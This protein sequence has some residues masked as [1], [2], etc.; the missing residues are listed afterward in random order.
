MVDDEEIILSYEPTDDLL[1]DVM[2][3]SLAQ[4]K[5]HKL[6]SRIVNKFK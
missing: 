5:F 6:M 2:T 3:K 4:C 1:D